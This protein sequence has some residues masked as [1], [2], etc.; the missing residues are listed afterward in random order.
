M[1]LL[2]GGGGGPGGDRRLEDLAGEDAV[3][4]SLAD[5]GDRMGDGLPK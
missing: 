2:S 4:L 5:G 1:G 3:V